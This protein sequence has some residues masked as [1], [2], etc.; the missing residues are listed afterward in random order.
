MSSAK[1]FFSR[2]FNDAEAQSSG[3]QQ[4][5]TFEHPFIRILTILVSVL[6][7]FLFNRVFTASTAYAASTVNGIPSYYCGS[8]TFNLSERCYATITWTGNIAAAHTKIFTNEIKPGNC[9]VQNTMWLAN[10][11]IS[12]TSDYW[13][14][15]GIKAD[16]NVNGGKDSAFWADNRPNGGG[17][18]NHFGNAL[19]S[20][21]HGKNADVYIF[22]S[23]GD[24]DGTWGVAIYGLPNTS[25]VGESDN[26]FAI[27]TD[28]D[29]GME[30][31]GSSNQYAP[32]NSFTYNQWA[33]PAATNYHYQG[34]NG[35]TNP[36]KNPANGYWTQEPI[37]SSTGGSWT[38][39][40]IGNGC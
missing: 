26:N 6:A 37:N 10:T 32:R 12:S 29:I 1:T 22:H 30:I 27:G 23:L 39:C 7:L 9:A 25:L 13:V 18:H 11:K 38:T 28:I 33:N 4:K 17:Y 15:A 40:I 20:T 31:C 8:A 5:H 14:E 3:I 21:D 35:S 19:T 2:W 34:N 36:Q 16:V 24:P